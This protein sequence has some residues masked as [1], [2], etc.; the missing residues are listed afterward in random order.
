LD[1]ADYTLFPAQ[2]DEDATVL[3]KTDV[4]IKQVRAPRTLF[5]EQ[6]IP[7]LEDMLATVEIEVQEKE[8]EKANALRSLEKA[9]VGA[10]DSVVEKRAWK[11]FESWYIARE[12]RLNFL[13]A[14]STYY[15]LTKR[16]W[17]AAKTESTEQVDNAFLMEMLEQNLH[18]T[19]LKVTR[20]SI[21]VH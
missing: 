4:S 19:D 13:S 10:V 12:K 11:G 6:D 18:V 14:S 9:I 5:S 16:Q 8:C 7:T 21:M 17:N 2:V 3:S 20:P 1:T 15:Y